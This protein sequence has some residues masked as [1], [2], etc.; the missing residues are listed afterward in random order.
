MKKDRGKIKIQEIS[1]VQTIKKKTVGASEIKKLMKDLVTHL[2]K[3]PYFFK[4]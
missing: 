2:K 4:K 3:R 1:M